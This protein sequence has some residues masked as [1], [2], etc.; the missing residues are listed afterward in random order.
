MKQSSTTASLGA[1]SE[2]SDSV[3]DLLQQIADVEGPDIKTIRVKVQLALAAAKSAWS[4]TAHYASRQIS[5]PGEY[6]RESPWQ[7]LGIAALL[8]IGV[9]A[10]LMRSHGDN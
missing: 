7:S 5:R 4:D 10:L 2:L 6:L 1:L 8:G 3:A 9:G